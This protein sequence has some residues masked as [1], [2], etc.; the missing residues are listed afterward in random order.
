M[1]WSKGQTMIY[2]TLH[3]KLNIEI[4]E[5]GVNSGVAEGLAVPA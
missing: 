4:H 1:Q 3:R 5:Q 2:N